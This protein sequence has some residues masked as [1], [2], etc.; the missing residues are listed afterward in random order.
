M[1]ESPA[2]KNS[3]KLP[4]F[5]RGVMEAMLVAALPGLALAFTFIYEAGYAQELNIPVGLIDLSWTTV[6]ISA[7]SLFF[8]FF[9]LYQVLDLIYIFNE[10]R[11]PVGRVFVL[12]YLG[13]WGFMLFFLFGFQ[14]REYVWFAGMAALLLSVEFGLPLITQRRVKGGYREKLRA[15]GRV[16]AKSSTQ[17][18]DSLLLTRL[19]RP[20]YLL[21]LLL[22]GSA[23][24]TYQVGQ[25]RALRRQTF[26]VMKSSD[27]RSLAVLRIYGDALV[28]APFDRES[29]R[30]TG[31]I[32]VYP[33]P[34]TDSVITLEEE[35]IG[36]LKLDD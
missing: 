29:R 5:P 32:L 21:I 8:T 36:P 1:S 19:G 9:V 20:G 28:A 25:S 26:P 2:V 16:Q 33:I 4:T 3:P 34:S 18:L 13:V 14:V 24:L 17:T 35:R 23:L 30:L 12:A 31:E 27:G 15:Q 11:I 7:S 10:G 6:L 22:L